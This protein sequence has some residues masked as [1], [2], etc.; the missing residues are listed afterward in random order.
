MN[1]T[2]SLSEYVATNL[3]HLSKVKRVNR[4]TR[5]GKNGKLITCP[6]CKESAPV[7]HFSWSAITCQFCSSDINK[8]DWLIIT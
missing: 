6:K 1:T 8:E 3:P 2:E 5:A 4:Y 7:F